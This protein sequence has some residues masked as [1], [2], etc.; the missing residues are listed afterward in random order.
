[1]GLLTFS[2]VLEKAIYFGDSAI[3]DDHSETM[4]GS[5]EDQVLTHDGQT[6]QTEVTTRL[7]VRRA[8]IDAGQSRTEVSMNR[9]P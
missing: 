4:I 2:F 7:T 9:Q 8:D 5:I 6:D 3:E 1:M